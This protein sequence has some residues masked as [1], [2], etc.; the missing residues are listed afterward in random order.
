MET[1]KALANLSEKLDQNGL[2]SY[3]DQIDKTAK[4]INKIVKAQFEGGLGYAIRNSRCWEKCYRENRVKDPNKSAQEVVFSCWDEYNKSIGDNDSGWEKYADKDAPIVKT[5]SKELSEKIINLVESGATVTE[6]FAAIDANERHKLTAA[7]IE[8]SEELL[9]ISSKLTKMDKK[10]SDELLMISHNLIKEAGFWGGVM[11]KGEVY[12]QG[13][14]HFKQDANI[15]KQLLQGI[16]SH[17]DKALNYTKKVSGFITKILQNLRYF[18]DQGGLAGRAIRPIATQAQQSLLPY[19]NVFLSVKD[20]NQA[21]K[22]SQ[23]LTSVVDQ[24][25]QQAGLV[26]QQAAQVEQQEGSQGEQAAQPTVLQ[27]VVN[28]DEAQLTVIVNNLLSNPDT[29]NAVKVWFGNISK[30][31][32]FN[33]KKYKYAQTDPSMIPQIMNAI[34]AKMGGNFTNW[35]NTNFAAK[36]GQIAPAASQPAREGLPAEAE[37][38]K[39]ES[40]QA[41]QLLKEVAKRAQE[42]LP[43]ITDEKIRNKVEY[44]IRQLNTLE[45]TVQYLEAMIAQT[46][47]AKKEEQGKM[48]GYHGTGGSPGEVT[49]GSNVYGPTE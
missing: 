19:N 30:T 31:A 34:Y 29:A 11:G 14:D 36:M 21:V 27:Q 48:M 24:L 22:S 35:F 9:K 37:A 3:A 44:R 47:Q 2:T 40:A 43:Q 12:K 41:I 1:I 28:A 32:S 16:V 20:A 5:A 39:M 13:L 15:L 38:P 26:E 10:A 33:F 25:L 42:V 8:K 46:A 18:Q 45:T 17:P 49:P 6:A 4:S 23:D 7:L